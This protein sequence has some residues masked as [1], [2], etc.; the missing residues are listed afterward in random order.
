ML[1]VLGKMTTDSS[2]IADLSLRLRL[3]VIHFA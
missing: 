3:V 2:L 1:P